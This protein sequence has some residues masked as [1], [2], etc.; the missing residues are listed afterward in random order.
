[1]KQPTTPT[2][3][4]LF[5]QDNLEPNTAEYVLLVCAVLYTQTE[6]STSREI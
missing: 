3:N 6:P 5:S 4:P 2:D 1:M